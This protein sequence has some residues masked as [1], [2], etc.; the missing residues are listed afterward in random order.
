M[1]IGGG[2]FVIGLGC[3]LLALT[4]DA[5]SG[6]SAIF[7]GLA[8][9]GVGVGLTTPVLVSAAVDAVPPHRAGMAGGAV[10]TARQLGMTLG[11]ALFGA[12]F[13]SRLRTV[14]GH[15]GSPHAAYASGL[16]RISLY[17]AAAG[18]AGAIAVFALVRPSRG[19]DPLPVDAPAAEPAAR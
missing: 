18:L 16:D 2:L 17:A 15:G 8:V 5:S 3:G 11:I 9:I 6:Q 1:P 13:T 19:A 4:V 7:A 10:N 12:V 14:A